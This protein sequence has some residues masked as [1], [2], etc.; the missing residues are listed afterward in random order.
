[1]VSRGS[2]LCRPGEGHRGTGQGRA[3]G[4]RGD[5]RVGYGDGRVLTR[6]LYRPGVVGVAI[7]GGV[8]GA[9]VAGQ[10]R[11]RAGQAGGAAVA[12]FLATRSC[13]DP[14]LISRGSGLMRPDEGHGGVA[15]LSVVDRRS[16]LRHCRVDGEGAVH[17]GEGVVGRRQRA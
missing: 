15:L 6:V 1:M 2:G 17:E 14:H 12:V 8:D 11:Q 7:Q 4:R 10:A 3:L 5:L 9:A 16:E 13:A